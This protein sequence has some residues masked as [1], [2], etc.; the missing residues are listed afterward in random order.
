MRSQAAH[1]ARAANRRFDKACFL[2]GAWIEPF[3]PKI[4]DLI[5]VVTLCG[6]GKQKVHT[7]KEGEGSIKYLI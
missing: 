6:E 1:T 4:F 5:L 7:R 2:L 3:Y